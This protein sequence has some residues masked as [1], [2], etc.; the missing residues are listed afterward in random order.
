MKAQELIKLCENAEAEKMYKWALDNKAFEKA[1]SKYPNYN[2][3]GHDD[4]S[5]AISFIKG[6]IEKKFGKLSDENEDELTD[7]I[8]GG[9]A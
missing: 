1:Y 5:D 7:M 8:S 4:H 3:M 9:L 2:D 6:E